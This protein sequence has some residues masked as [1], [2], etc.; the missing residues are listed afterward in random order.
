MNITYRYF[1][2]FFRFIRNLLSF[3]KPSCQRFCTVH[4]SDPQAKIFSEVGCLFVD[5]LLD[6]EDVRNLFVMFSPNRVVFRWMSKVIL[7]LSDFALLHSVARLKTRAT[8]S[9]NKTHKTRTNR[10][11][12]AHLFPRLGIRILSS[13]AESVSERDTFSTI[14]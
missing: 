14:R 7:V 3:Y 2:L 10:D 1:I 5:F 6:G 13:R 11:L 8:F 4:I 9:T 12:L